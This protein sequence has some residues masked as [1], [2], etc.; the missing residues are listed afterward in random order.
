M[1]EKKNSTRGML[2]ASFR[3]GLAAE[4]GDVDGRLD[5][6]GIH[7]PLETETV[8][9]SEAASQPSGVRGNL[10]PVKARVKLLLKDIVSNPFNPRTYYSPEAIDALAVKLKRDGQYETIKVTENHRYPGKYVIIDGEYRYRAMKSMGEVE[11][12]AEITPL[13]SDRDL[14]LVA[15]RINK[16]RTPQTVFDDAV[17][18]QKLL[19]E[20]IFTDQDRLAADLDMQKSQ[21]SKV[22]RLNKLPAPLLQR[23]AEH[24]G[25]V[26]LSH[27]YSLLLIFERKGMETAEGLLERVI[28]G[29]ISSKQLEQFN[30]K[31]AEQNESRQTRSHYSARVQF[32]AANGAELGQLKH[33]RD[34]RTELKLSGLNEQQQEALSERLEAVVREFVEASVN[35]GLPSQ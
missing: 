8:A 10:P 22:L 24:G 27:A 32:A 28:A 17:A 3:K 16:D 21:L 2:G 26:G 25:Q 13:L 12:D 29:E 20:G 15:S 35:P 19:D 33:F 7:A 9:V 31:A 30:A 23:M 14:Y 1:T 11:I 34:G 4:R 6:Q 5:A 18:W